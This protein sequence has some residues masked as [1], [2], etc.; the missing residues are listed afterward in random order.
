MGKNMTVK[1]YGVS[2][3]PVSFKSNLEFLFQW[4]C[5]Y[6]SWCTGIEK[7]EPLIFKLVINYKWHPCYHHS[8]SLLPSMQIS[9]WLFTPFQGMCVG[10]R[11]LNLWWEIAFHGTEILVLWFMYNSIGFVHQLVFEPLPWLNCRLELYFGV[12]C[13]QN[14]SVRNKV[15]S[16]SNLTLEL[17]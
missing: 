4:N 1:I 6:D 3:Y 9:L 16:I 15:Q 17:L 7:Y 2:N 13:I 11:G 14:F 10:H 12:Q 8:N 5:T